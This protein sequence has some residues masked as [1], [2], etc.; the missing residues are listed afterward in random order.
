MKRILAP[1]FFCV[2]LF[3]EGSLGGG[4][5]VAGEIIFRDCL[6][7]GFGE[8]LEDGLG[9]VVGIGAIGNIDMQVHL[10]SVGKGAE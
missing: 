3:R 1:E 10:G 6:T 2:V 9:N 4:N 5:G 7:E 8:C